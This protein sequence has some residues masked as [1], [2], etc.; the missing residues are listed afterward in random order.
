MRTNYLFLF[1]VL[2]ISKSCIREEESC[3]IT[4]NSKITGLLSDG[5]KFHGL[6]MN[7][8]Q[9]F[10]LFGERNA[11][12]GGLINK[13]AI[14]Y[15]SQNFGKT[16]NEIINIKGVF[17]KAFSFK[18]DL[19]AIREI[20]TAQSFKDTE[21]FL[22]K[23]NTLN[24][25]FENI[26]QFSTDAFVREL[27]F[28]NNKG[29]IIVRN[30]G[31]SND[32]YLYRILKNSKK[33][34]SLFINK[35]I[36]KAISHKE[37]VYL[38]SYKNNQRYEWL[39]TINKNN[40]IDSL[41]LKFSTNEFT[42]DKSGSILLLG[43]NNNFLELRKKEDGKIKTVNIVSQKKE[44]TPKKLYKYDEFIAILTCV[45]DR[46]ALGG[47]G[48]SKYNLYISFDGGETFKKEK[49]LVSNFADPI[50]FYKDEKIVVYSGAGRI[51]VCD[52]N[53]LKNLNKL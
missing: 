33:H 37:K 27:S 48:G 4:Y 16:W 24:N 52:L 21:L 50:G 18:N 10:F 3:W 13:R 36:V 51:S 6:V 40:Q 28:D 44:E 53:K 11:L 12:D 45:I 29:N 43:K 5:E 34:D 9:D 22:T 46:Q 17:N 47:F 23:I 42:I 35:P 7:D 26:Y 1:I 41:D 2:L 15:K 39:Y 31:L 30:S 49:L 8:N 14:V 25:H 20:F 19:Y 38:L 32:Y